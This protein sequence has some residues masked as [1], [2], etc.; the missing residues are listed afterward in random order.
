[1]KKLLT[2]LFVSM[3]TLGYAVH[4]SASASVE[5]IELSDNSISVTVKGSV[6]HVCGAAGQ[7]LYPAAN[8]NSATMTQRR[9]RRT[10]LTDLNSTNTAVSA[11]STPCTKKPNNWVRSF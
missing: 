10:T 11:T 1:M 5:I 8:A 6:L 7:T 4:S 9:T 3:L 2:I